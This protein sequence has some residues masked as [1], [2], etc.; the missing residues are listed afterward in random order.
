MMYLDDD[1]T[2]GGSS[3]FPLTNGLAYWN[4][5]F[6]PDATPPVVH[7]GDTSLWYSDMMNDHWIAQAPDLNGDPAIGGIDEI[8]GYAL[9]YKSQASMPSAGIAANGDLYLSFSGYTETIDNGTQVFR[10]IYVTKSED[11]GTT[12]KTPVDV[13]PHDDWAGMQECVYGSMSPIVDDKIRIVYQLDFEPGLAVNG[14]MDMVDYNAIVYLEIDTA[15]LFDGSTTAIIETENN[16]KVNDNRIFDVL[17]REWKSN[18]ADLPKGVY[19]INGKKV[20]KTN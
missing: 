4:E 1:L 12:W 20:F 10:H 14:D 2:D 5:S 17:G 19:I 3:W 8:G 16:L 7:A 6:G 9:Y 15:G 18:F 11:G 13:T